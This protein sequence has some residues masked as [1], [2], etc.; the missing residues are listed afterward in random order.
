MN[1]KPVSVLVFRTTI[2]F[3]SRT[4]LRLVL[5]YVRSGALFDCVYFVLYFLY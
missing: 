5:H 1:V 4:N 2:C 3:K